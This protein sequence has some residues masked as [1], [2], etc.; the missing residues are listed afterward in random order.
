MKRMKAVIL[1]GILVLG[2]GSSVQGLAAG[3]VGP[4]EAVSV[5]QS[6][7]QVG[8]FA[9]QDGI[10]YCEVGSPGTISGGVGSPSLCVRSSNDAQFEYVA[11]SPYYKVFF[12]DTVMRMQFEHGWIELG[13]PEQEL[14]KIVSTE[15]AAY[16][17]ALSVANVFESV[18]LS[19]TVGTS[20]LKEAF[21][22]KASKDLERIIL[23]I[24]WEGVIPVSEED[25]SIV[26]LDGNEKAVKILPPFMEDAENNVC[27]DIHYELVETE[28]GHELH[29]V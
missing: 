7:G 14:G 16:E 26:F 11:A 13:V 17:N 5:N 19:Y 15:S 8:R 9:L 28:T 27:T 23:E 21:T 25:G 10:P 3:M 2:L 24:S 4:P 1:V 6:L 20:V 29:K 18:D 22:L 12:K